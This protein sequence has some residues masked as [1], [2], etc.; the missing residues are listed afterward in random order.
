MTE[1]IYTPVCSTGELP[2]GERLFLEV[3]D[4]SIVVLNQGGDYYAI[5]DLCTHDDGPLGEG[6]VEGHE[7]ICPRHGARFDIRTGEVLSLPAI[8]DVPVYP[9]RVVDGMIEIGIES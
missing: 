5:A 2:E 4:T 9:V 6:E 1:I 7:I 3:G 8:H